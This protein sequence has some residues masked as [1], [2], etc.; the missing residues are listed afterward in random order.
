MSVVVPQ[1]QIKVFALEKSLERREETIA[2]VT[3]TER[4]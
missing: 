3:A 4:H 1:S 2:I